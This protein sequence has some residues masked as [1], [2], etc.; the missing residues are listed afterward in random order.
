[1][2]DGAVSHGSSLLTFFLG[3]LCELLCFPIKICHMDYIH[4]PI[5]LLTA[6]SVFKKCPLRCIFFHD[7][8]LHPRKLISFTLVIQKYCTNKYGVYICNI[9]V[10]SIHII[11]LKICFKIFLSL[12]E[13]K[14]VLKLWVSYTFSHII[15]MYA[16]PQI[17][18]ALG[19]SVL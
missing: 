3:E 1:M 15:P 8:S 6:T 9:Y 7:M 14:N 10:L 12:L 11:M 17:C 16:H 2:A 13:S 18:K 4:R 5:Y 19:L